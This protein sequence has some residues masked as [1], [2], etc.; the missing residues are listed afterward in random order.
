MKRATKI[1]TLAG[2]AGGIALGVIFAPARGA[3][4]RTRLKKNLKRGCHY[5]N[6]SCTV[7]KL[8]IEKAK[9]EMQMQDLEKHLDKINCK[10]KGFTEKEKV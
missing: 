9:T 1:L 8:F 6:G 5:L 4:T 10:I 2:F 3:E 7:K